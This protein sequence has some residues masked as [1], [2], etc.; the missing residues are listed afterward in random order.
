MKKWLGAF[1]LCLWAVSGTSAQAAPLAKRVFMPGYID[2]PVSLALFLSPKMRPA[3]ETL[4]KG[5][6]TAA[7]KAFA[8]EILQHPNNLA[9]YVGLLQATSSQEYAELLPQ[10]VNQAELSSLSA[11]EFKLGVLAWYMLLERRQEGAGKEETEMRKLAELARRGLTR[12]YSGTQAPIAGFTLAFAFTDIGGKN[13]LPLYEDML[14]RMAGER[15]Y[16]V[17]MRAKNNGWVGQQPPI[18]RL[19]RNDLL[20][21]Y[22]VVRK[23]WSKNSGRGGAISTRIVNGKTIHETVWA[24]YTPLQQRAMAYLRQWYDHIEDVAEQGKS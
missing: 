15:V 14:K 23:I 21:L 7:R 5:N 22:G 8:S 16:G 6:L 11:D 3:C 1:L 2:Y 20:I 17:Y 9:A 13:P 18:P 10:Y 4:Q 24:P 12:A 19:S